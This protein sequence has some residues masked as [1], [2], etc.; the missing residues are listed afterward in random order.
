MR[1]RYFLGSTSKNGGIGEVDE[2]NVAEE[3]VSGEDVEEELAVPVGGRVGH[4]EVD[5]EIEVA[6]VSRLP[7]RQ[8]QIDRRRASALVAA[9]RPAVVVHH[10]EI[11]FIDILGGKEEPV[12]VRPHGPLRSHGNR[13]A[14]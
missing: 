1:K 5:V 13:P 12:V 14:H 2:R 7:L 6:E 9:I 11:A 4:D 3:A 10:H 8:A